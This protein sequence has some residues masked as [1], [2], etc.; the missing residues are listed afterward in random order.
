VSFLVSNLAAKHFSDFL[1][2]CN[3]SLAAPE[4]KTTEDILIAQHFSSPKD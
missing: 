4:T 2:E 3:D 1:Q